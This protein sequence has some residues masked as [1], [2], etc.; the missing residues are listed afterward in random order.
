MGADWMRNYYHQIYEYIEKLTY[1]L[2]KEDK[3]GNVVGDESLQLMDLL[4][5][6]LIDTGS[7]ASIQ[8]L[9]TETGLKRNDLVA[10]VKRLTERNMLRKE[11]A[12]Q[13]RRIQKLLLTD[14]GKEMLAKFRNEKQTQLFELLNEFTFN[15]E[16]AILKFLVKIEMKHREINSGSVV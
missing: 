9:V 15:E 13:D 14:M 16:K 8:K 1:L 12:E 4:V 5:M 3:R 11:N 7:E 6:V 10:A 2:M